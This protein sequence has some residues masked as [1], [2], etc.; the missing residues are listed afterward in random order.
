MIF[1][2]KDDLSKRIAMSL[3]GVVQGQMNQG[4]NV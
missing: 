4:E 3:F 2:A 1:T